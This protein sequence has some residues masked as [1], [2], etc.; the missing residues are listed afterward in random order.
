MSDEPIESPRS[1]TVAHRRRRGVALVA[2]GV[3]VVAAGAVVLFGVFDAGPPDGSAQSG[4]SSA[5]VPGSSVATEPTA[6]TSSAS[7]PAETTTAGDLATFSPSEEKVF[8]SGTVR[9]G[10][11]VDTKLDLIGWFAVDNYGDGHIAFTDVGLVGQNGTQFA[12]LDSGSDTSFGSCRDQTVWTDSI[13]WGQVRRGS[14]ACL[15]TF[16]GR[17]GIIR[18]DEVPDFAQSEPVTVLT[19][20]IWETTVDR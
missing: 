20:S 8:S 19:G 16:L 14:F 11:R 17:R 15:R 12:L 13:D 9:L 3:V 4:G 1:G 2:A 6:G 5:V 7:R 18:V 10:L